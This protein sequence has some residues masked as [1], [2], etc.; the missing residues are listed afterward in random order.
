MFRKN[1]ISK[2]FL[3]FVL[4]SSPV[5]GDVNSTREILGHFSNHHPQVLKSYDKLVYQWVNYESSYP[6]EWDLD[7]LLLAVEFAAIKH[8]KQTRKDEEKT[9]Y[10]IHPI[11]VAKLL[12]EVGEIR[13][14]N[15][16]IAALLHDTLEDTD[17]TEEEIE[18]LF[19]SRVL[20]TVKELT[21]DPTL[22][23]QENK[24]RQ[25]DHA[26]DLSLNGQLVKLADR[27]YNVR[28]LEIPPPSWTQ[29]KI[30]EYRKW[31]AKLL[32]ALRGTNPQLENALAVFTT[33]RSV[34]KAIVGHFKID[35]LCYLWVT[36]DGNFQEYVRIF[37]ENGTSWS[38]PYCEQLFVREGDRVEVVQIS[39]EDPDYLE[40]KRYRIIVDNNLAQI[41][42][43]PYP[44][45][46]RENSFY[47]ENPI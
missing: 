25:V 31:G 37:L 45:T 27:L 44:V 2:L 38:F 16:L 29:E 35:A 39:S 42:F 26:K 41:S 46:E 13:S 40:G 21:N 22:N 15:V 20:E 24:Q 18:H 17:A 5:F 33:E 43:Y 14:S 9:P 1:L 7:R 47:S 19:G 36:L 12:W 11:G 23:T 10:I 8:E 32:I 6:G 3:F 4:V 34:A 30:D 28:D